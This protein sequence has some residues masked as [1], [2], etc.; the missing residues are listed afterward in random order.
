MSADARQRIVYEIID[1]SNATPLTLS[2][3]VGPIPPDLIDIPSD[4]WTPEQVSH[5]NNNF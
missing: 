5:C 4:Q 3:S 1:F 2:V